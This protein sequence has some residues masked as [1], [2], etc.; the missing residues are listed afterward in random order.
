M[1]AIQLHG[2]RIKK[3]HATAILMFVAIL[4]GCERSQ[5]VVKIHDSTVRDM[6]VQALKTKDFEY[7]IRQDGSIVVY[8]DMES[9]DRDMK[10]FQLWE[11][12]YF[13]YDKDRTK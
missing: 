2:L 9:L 8:T 13:S 7:E 6:Y 5:T 3:M 11:N 10:E 4:I 1:G 12:K